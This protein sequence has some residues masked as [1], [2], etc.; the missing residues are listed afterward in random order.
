MNDEETVALIAGGHAFGKSHG[1]VK[2]D[3]IGAPPEIAAIEEMGLGWHNPEGSGNA[4]FT[5]TNG[6]EGSWTQNPTQWDNSYL[7]NLLGLG[8]NRRAARLARCNGRRSAG[9]RRARRMRISR[10][11]PMR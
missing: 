3:R 9:T 5:M 7:E 2:A 10:A 1:M 6:I 4:E 11:R 8:G